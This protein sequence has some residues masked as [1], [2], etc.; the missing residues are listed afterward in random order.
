MTDTPDDVRKGGSYLAYLLRLWR[1]NGISD[2]WLASL[3]SVDTHSRIGF[4]GLEALFEYI[5]QKTVEQGSVADAPAKMEVEEKAGQNN[6][7]P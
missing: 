4:S 1:K 6:R 3:E 7:N 5:R 2:Y